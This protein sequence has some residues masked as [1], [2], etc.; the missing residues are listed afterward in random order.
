MR[1]D[2]KGKYYT[3]RVSTE[4]LEVLV[5]TARGQ[6]RGFLHVRPDRRLSDELNG[7][8]QFLAITDATVTDPAGAT[9]YRTGFLA[10][11]KNEVVWVVPANAVKQE[12]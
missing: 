5:E 7:E 12:A 1:I 11:N 6:V 9:L 2:S 10:L 8:Q 3:T 4:L